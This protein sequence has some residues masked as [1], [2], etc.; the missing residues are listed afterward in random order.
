MYGVRKSDMTILNRRGLSESCEVIVL[1]R[2]GVDTK[3]RQR[4]DPGFMTRGEL[5]LDRRVKF[6]GSEC[7]QKLKLLL[8]LLHLSIISLLQKGSCTVR[9]H[10]SVSPVSPHH[11]PANSHQL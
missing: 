3:L 7:T 5:R 4:P 9:V 10:E 1:A 11:T 6:K 2:L 8:L